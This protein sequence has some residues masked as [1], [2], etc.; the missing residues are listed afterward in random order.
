M[1]VTALIVFREFL[2]AFLLAGVFLGMSKQ[3]NLKKEFEIILALAIGVS[4][5]VLLATGVFF[6][7]DSARAVITE[8]SAE[9]L[10]GYL[11]LFSGVFIAYVV[12]ALHRA[13]GKANRDAVQ[14]AK[15]VLQAT[16]FDISFFFLIIFLVLREGFEIAL[17]TA[18]VSLFADFATNMLGLFVGFVAA[19]I[20][21]VG[22]YFF[23]TKIPIKKVFTATEYAIVGLGAVFTSNGLMKML[24]GQF[25]INVTGILP[26]SVPF[27]E[28]AVSLLSPLIILAY[29]GA[30]YFLFLRKKPLTT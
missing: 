23:Y 27:T 14:M 9:L 5:S 21:G 16:A 4:I 18:S 12:F 11:M 17:F 7:G 29:I 13:M 24:E 8:A 25:G 22:I 15:D 20:V 28:Y 19:T 3:M 1:L 6:F 26:I 2:E 30:V 10:E